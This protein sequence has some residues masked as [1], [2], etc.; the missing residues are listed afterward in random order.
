MLINSPT[1]P[2]QEGGPRDATVVEGGPCAARM[3]DVKLTETAVPWFFRAA[4]VDFINAHARV[5][6]RK[7]VKT[8]GPL[9]IAAIDTDPKVARVEWRDAVP[10]PSIS[11]GRFGRS[12]RSA[13]LA[14]YVHVVAADRAFPAIGVGLMPFFEMLRIDVARGL[15]DGRWTF[16]VDVTRDLWPIL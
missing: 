13:V 7:M 3:V 14:P 1:W 10:F 5:E 6:I 16:G 12:P 4:N 8:K 15:R 11:L 9:P 2:L